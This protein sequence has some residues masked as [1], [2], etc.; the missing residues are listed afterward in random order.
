MKKC[1]RRCHQEMCLLIQL[2]GILYAPLLCLQKCR[3]YFHARQYLTISEAAASF[4]RT[5]FFINKVLLICYGHS[6][7]VCMYLVLLHFIEDVS[8]QK[9][10][11][12]FFRLSE[13]FKFCFF[14]SMR[15]YSFQMMVHI[16]STMLKEAIISLRKLKGIQSDGILNVL[17]SL[18]WV[19][20]FV[21]AKDPI[22]DFIECAF[23]WNCHFPHFA[24][25]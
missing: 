4:G 12:D 18:N 14:K 16:R 19:I 10:L 25:T 9:L 20:D 21:C 11:N 3:T 6:K 5:E 24:K 22:Q 13:S 2:L 15:E 17:K 8:L 1:P 23:E 7:Y